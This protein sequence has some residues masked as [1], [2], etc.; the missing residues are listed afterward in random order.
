MNSIKTFRFA[1]GI[2]GLACLIAYAIM[3]YNEYSLC[4]TIGLFAGIFVIAFLFS[5][6]FPLSLKPRESNYEAVMEK[7][8]R[9]N[10]LADETIAKLNAVGRTQIAVSNDQSSNIN[11]DHWGKAYYLVLKLWAF[12]DKLNADPDFHKSTKELQGVNIQETTKEKTANTFVGKLRYLVLVDIVENI[13]RGG[14][15]FDLSHDEGLILLLFFTKITSHD[16]LDKQADIV[17]KVFMSQYSRLAKDCEVMV[18]KFMDAIPKVEQI[19]IISYCL[20]DYSK[21][22]Q[23]EYLLLMHE[24]TSLYSGVDNYLSSQEKDWQDKLLSLINA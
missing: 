3:Y 8:K 12:V 1:L 16:L 15:A 14:H 11:Y 17:Y 7:A 10:A 19:F 6:L 24:V 20:C 4:N 18:N 13:R 5:I 9:A 23:K 2:I 21:D 22:L